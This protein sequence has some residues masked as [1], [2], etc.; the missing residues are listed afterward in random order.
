MVRYPLANAGDIR[1]VGLIPRLGRFL[2]RGHGNP[3]QYS[4]IQNPHGWGNLAG[5]SPLGHIESDTAE[6]T[7]GTV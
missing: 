6:V 1:D 7:A 3:L 5:Y 2:G 4:C